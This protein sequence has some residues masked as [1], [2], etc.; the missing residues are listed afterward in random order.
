MPRCRG[1]GV[2]VGVRVR[3]RVASIVWPR[4]PDEALL[5]QQR[6]R[7]I[8]RRLRTRFAGPALEGSHHRLVEVVGRVARVVEPLVAV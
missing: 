8:E 3:V 2:G 1:V 4:R 7:A 6:R 5:E